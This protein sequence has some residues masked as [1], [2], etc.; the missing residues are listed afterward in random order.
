MHRVVVLALPGVI[1]FDMAIPFQVFGDAYG[2]HG[3]PLYEVMLA[4][5]HR[6]S[7]PT[8]AGFSVVVDRGI[9]ALEGAQT[10]VVVGSEPALTAIDETVRV[11]LLGAMKR[12]VRLMSIC[13]GAYVLAETGL[14][15]GR[16][17]ST[18]WKHGERFRSRYPGV[19]LDTR[20]LYTDD[21]QLLTS[22]GAAAGIDLCLHVVARDYGVAAANAVARST[23]SAPYRRGGQAQY[24]EVAG[25][26]PTANGLETTRQWARNRLDSPIS[27]EDLA[28]HAAVS[29]RTL[30][31]KFLAETGTSPLK[32]LTEQR[33]LLARDLLEQRVHPLEDVARR[34]GFG[35]QAA[36][37][38]HFRRS[39]ATS[40]S[41]YR[42]EFG[43][44]LGT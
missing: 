26:S 24:I 27:L 7:L 39:L 25:L 22:A 5:S 17:A 16:R 34:A 19:E 44:R 30:V 12:G 14:L 13:T 18:H 11:A 40:P 20:A 23:V 42:E 15:E 10:I 36:M 28:R 43:P 1:P 33:V 38:L 32:W 3:E 6:G 31:R 37:R 4:G 21:G 35:S 9:S 2:T 41:A 29:R 8:S